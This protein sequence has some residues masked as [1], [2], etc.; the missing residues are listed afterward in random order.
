MP[1]S[2]GRWLSSM[3]MPRLY[4]GAPSAPARAG[5]RPGAIGYHGGSLTMPGTP[6]AMTVAAQFQIEYLQY[7][8][9]DGKPVA[10][11][12]QAFRDPAS[13][14][15]MFKQMLFVRTFDAK[16]IALQRTG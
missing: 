6:L 11:L 4:G 8:G 15:P 1:S 12:P 16:A 9:E 14:L 13:L 10:E 3:F 2:S 5:A 7:L